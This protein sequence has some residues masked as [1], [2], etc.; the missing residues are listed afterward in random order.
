M[1][2]LT[3]NNTFNDNLLL[4]KEYSKM[5]NLDFSHDKNTYIID[6]YRMAYNPKFY[7]ENVKK[8]FEFKY[9]FDEPFEFSKK[10]NSPVRILKLSEDYSF[11]IIIH[12]NLNLCYWYYFLNFRSYSEFLRK[13]IKSKQEKE[14]HQC[15]NQINSSK[16]DCS[17]C[18]KKLCGQCKIVVNFS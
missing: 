15:K 12:D 3:L 4:P 18:N 1:W 10:I 8:I 13:I 9:N 5:N 7:T 17:V 16:Y 2:R 11:L 14:C 6:S